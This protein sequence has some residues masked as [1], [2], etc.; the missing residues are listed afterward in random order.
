MS[1]RG[2]TNSWRL[3]SFAAHLARQQTQIFDK[4]YRGGT[5]RYTS[6]GVG[7]G[8]PIAKVMVAAHGGSIAVVSQLGSRSVFSVTIPI[9][10]DPGASRLQ[11]FPASFLD[12]RS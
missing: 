2:L 8:L 4:F 7:M 11:E 6:P 1:R 3:K 9:Y 10:V 5:Q 12:R